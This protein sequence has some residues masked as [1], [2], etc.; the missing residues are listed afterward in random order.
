M[1]NYVLLI[2]EDVPEKYHMTGEEI[3]E[4]IL[5]FDGKHEDVPALLL[6]EARKRDPDVP[7]LSKWVEVIPRQSSMT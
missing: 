2:R 3:D 5:A 1:K 6:K 4:I 7:D